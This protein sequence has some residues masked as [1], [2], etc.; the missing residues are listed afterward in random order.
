MAMKEQRLKK[1][2]LR[3]WKNDYLINRHM[4]KNIERVVSIALRETAQKPPRVLDV[5][6][7]NK[8]YAD[9]FKGCDYQGM[10]RE[11]TDGDPD[12]IGDVTSIPVGS[13]TMDIVF[14]T[15]VIEHVPDPQAMVRECHKILRRGGFLILTGPFYWPLHEEP[16]DYHRFTRYGFDNLLSNAGFSSWEIWPDGGN[17][18]QIFLSINLQLRRVC[19]IPLIMLFNCLGL[20]MDYL[21]HEE[22]IP[23]NYTILARS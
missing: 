12:I 16:R 7:G 23:A 2:T 3:I 18:T 10:D 1:R 6:C 9:L 21:D 11:A 15:Q 14:S 8:P 19:F 17:W 13:G 20:V 4:W 5:G 22:T